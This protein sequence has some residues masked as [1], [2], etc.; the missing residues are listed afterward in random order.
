LLISQ[1]I[2]FIG[3]HKIIPNNEFEWA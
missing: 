2:K 1:I 3:I